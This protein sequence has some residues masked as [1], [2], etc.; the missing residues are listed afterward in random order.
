MLEPTEELP[1]PTNL[2]TQ[3]SLESVPP[4]TADRQGEFTPPR[5]SSHR[6]PALEE[7]ADSQ[8]KSGEEHSEP[9]AS[10]SQPPVEEQ[11]PATI[12]GECA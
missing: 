2:E 4:T 7:S 9:N 8:T 3:I 10:A 6:L 5:R 11:T 12:A 1:P